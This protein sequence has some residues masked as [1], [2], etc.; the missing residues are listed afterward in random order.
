LLIP[1]HFTSHI[2]NRFLDWLRKMENS[3]EATA[4]WACLTIM[5]RSMEAFCAR[6]QSEACGLLKDLFLLLARSDQ[7]SF[8]SK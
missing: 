3:T 6:A 4:T 1:G 7:N 5:G 2:P 8:D